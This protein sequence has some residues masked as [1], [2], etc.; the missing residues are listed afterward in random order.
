MSKTEYDLIV[1]LPVGP[2][3]D[4]F[5]INDTIE[6]IY[7]YCRCHLRIIIADDSQQGLGEKSRSLFPDLDVLVN[8]KSGGLG[9]GL[10]ITLAHAFRFALE[11]YRFKTLFKIDTDALVIGDN[12]QLDAEK[13][14][15]ARPDTGMA[16]LY[17]SG[18]ELIDFNNNVFDNRWPRNYMFDITCTWKVL[19]RPVANSALKK[20]FRLAFA[21]GY[22]I[23]ENIFGGAYFFSEAAL[24]SLSAAGLLPVYQLK[25]SRMEEDH[26]FSML[27]K[28][29]NFEMGDLA[30]G[31]LPFGVMWQTLPASPEKLLLKKKK[32]IH[33]TRSW[34]EL[35]ETGIRQFFR[36]IRESGRSP[37]MPKY[38]TGLHP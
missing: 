30:A 7:H 31:E 33:S 5:F 32:V 22:E 29:V 1:V 18:L 36:K 12:P 37:E 27:V 11:N 15:S 28:V 14:F 20:Y 13:L 34:K 8:K 4:T 24:I 17:K 25:N 6:S 19:K 35:D 21:N 26:I 38:A 23:G 3:T 2:G 9:G 10:Y 16:G